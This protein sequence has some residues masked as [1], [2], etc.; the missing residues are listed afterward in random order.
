VVPDGTIF[1]M[2]DN[3]DNSLDSRFWGPVPLSYVKGRAVLIYWSYE[4][5]RD[6]WEWKGVLSRL[7]QLAEVFLN[8]FTKTRWGRMFQIIE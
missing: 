3:R 1:C 2:G 5:E 6:D 8:F 7:R 4:A